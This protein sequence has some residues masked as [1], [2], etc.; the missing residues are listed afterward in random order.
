MRMR[1]GGIIGFSMVLMCSGC[2]GHKKIAPVVQAPP[3]GPNIISFFSDSKITPKVGDLITVQVVENASGSKKSTSSAD[4]NTD[5]SADM[6]MDTTDKTY[7]GKLGMKTK[8]KY[9]ADN[10]YVKQGSLVAN[11][12]AVVEEVYPNGNARISGTQEISIDKGMQVITL[13]GIA[14]PEDISNTNTILSTRLAKAKIS[15]RSK[16]EPA[17]HRQSLLGWLVGLVF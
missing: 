2:F 12:T 11:V 8:N 15:Y 1:L 13:T 16:N 7:D 9:D 6:K 14:R 4:K 3:A 10:R 17:I 5:I